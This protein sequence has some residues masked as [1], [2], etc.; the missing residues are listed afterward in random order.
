MNNKEKVMQNTYLKLCDKN[1]LQILDGDKEVEQYECEGQK[2]SLGLPSLSGPDICK[3]AKQFGITIQYGSFSRWQY[4]DMLIKESIKH[5]KISEVL[6]YLLSK[7]HILKIWGGYPR[8]TMENIC[9]RI[10]D[11]TIDCINGELF[12]WDLE[13]YEQQGQYLIRLTKNLNNLLKTHT[14]ID[15]DYINERMSKAYACIENSDYDSA[16]TKARTIVEEAFIWGIAKQNQEPLKNGDIGYLYNQ[17][18]SLYH[19]HQDKNTDK[20]INDL[21]SGLNKIVTSIS[22]MRNNASDSHGLGTRRI[23]IAAHHTKL[24]VDAAVLLAD[25]VQSVVEHASNN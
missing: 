8:K 1:I 20:R 4:M 3:L 15:N 24:V 13:L 2:L 5:N 18:K 11:K 19:M 9:K 10:H 16:V 7:P 12:A 23:P 14:H 6:A 22:E 17:F 21:L 25:F